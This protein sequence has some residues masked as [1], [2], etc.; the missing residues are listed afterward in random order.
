MSKISITE[1][2]DIAIIFLELNTKNI[3]SCIFNISELLHT[4]VSIKKSFKTDGGPLKC[5]Y[6]QVYGDIVFTI[7]TASNCADDN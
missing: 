1:Q 2:S 6:C 7:F 5:H 3:K 4:F